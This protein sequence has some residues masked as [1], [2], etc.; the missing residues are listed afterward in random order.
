[1]DLCAQA[2]GVKLYK[3]IDAD[4]NVT[5]QD[6]PLP[7]NSAYV[8]EKDID[9]DEVVTVPAPPARPLPR[10]SVPVGSNGGF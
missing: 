1:M 4:G 10:P 6:H 5:Y 7:A 2:H 8:E 9:P 3:W